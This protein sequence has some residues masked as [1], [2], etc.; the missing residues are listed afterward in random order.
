M[1]PILIITSIL[2]VST[3]LITSNWGMSHAIAGSTL[4]NNTEIST[5]QKPTIVAQRST[6]NLEMECDGE[7]TANLV[8]FTAYYSQESGFSRIEFL[9]GSPE[10]VI[11]ESA[12]SYDG[13]NDQGQSIWRGSVNGMAS[14]TLIHLSSNPA[15]PGD[16]IS[17]SYDGQWGK[18]L[19]CQTKMW[20]QPFQ[21]TLAKSTITRPQTGALA[22]ISH[23]LTVFLHK[24][25]KYPIVTLPGMVK[26]FLTYKLPKR[27][28]VVMA[29]CKQATL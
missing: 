7:I 3:N 18:G 23:F 4:L 17:V 15:Q 26:W 19:C 24:Q 12:L 29:T 9:Q 6:G 22:A 2:I 1:N 25:S 16:E 28:L 27:S 14:V 13:Q 21:Q 8:D 5:L 11:A 20:L 10:Q